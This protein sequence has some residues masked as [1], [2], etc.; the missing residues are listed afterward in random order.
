[1]AI[2]DTFTSKAAQLGGTGTTV[3]NDL[4]IVS[5][6]L[7]CAECQQPIKATITTTQWIKCE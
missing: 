7:L 6:L 2:P 4:Y 1:M 3:S 5:V